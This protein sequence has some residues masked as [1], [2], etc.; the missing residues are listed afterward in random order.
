M[1]RYSEE[2]VEK[3][4]RLTPIKFLFSRKESKGSKKKKKIWLY[5]CAC[6]NKKALPQTRAKLGYVLSCG[7]LQKESQ[8]RNCKSG[9]QKA[10]KLKKN[11]QKGHKTNLGRKMNRKTDA[12]NK[13]KIAIYEFPNRPLQGKRKYVTEKELQKIWTGE[14]ECDWNRE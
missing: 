4:S 5:Q 7:C 8:L 6:G 12:P 3:H 9:R 11:F 14:L 1:K 2:Y 10:V 13:G